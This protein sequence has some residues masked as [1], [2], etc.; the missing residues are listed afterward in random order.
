MYN[1]NQA[2]SMS[3]MIRIGCLIGGLLIFQQTTFAF[4]S[5][6]PYN[7]NRTDEIK[8][9]E[10]HLMALRLDDAN[11]ALFQYRQ[12]QP[13]NLLSVYLEHYSDF[14]Y[15]LIT[16]DQ[17]A[18]ERLKTS[19]A[20]RRE[21]ISKGPSTS[22]WRG[23]LMA[24]ISLHQ[25]GL[26]FYGSNFIRGFIGMRSAYREFEVN[27]QSHP[28]F[29]TNQKSMGLLQIMVTAIPSRYARSASFL[30]GI[31]ADAVG[32]RRMMRTAINHHRPLND[33]IYKESSILY[34]FLLL[35][36]DGKQEEAYQFAKAQNWDTRNALMP[37]FV[38]ANLAIYTGRND[39]AVKL[40]NARPTGSRYVSIPYIYYMHGETLLRAGDY[41]ASSVAF[42]KFVSNEKGEDYKKD[43]LQKAAWA[44]LL[45]NN[46]TEY[47]N[48][49]NRI[50]RTGTAE[51]NGDKA[52]EKEARQ[53]PVPH[54]ELLRAGL[55]YD[56][57]YYV[58]SLATLDGIPQS[59]LNQAAMKSEFHYRRAR[60]LDK[61]KRHEEAKVEFEL[62]IDT[63]KNL[64][65]HFACA[66]ALRFGQ[67]LESLGNIEKARNAF[68]TCLQLKPELYADGLHRQAK[69]ALNR[70][71]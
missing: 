29:I 42:L 1:I 61:L 33:F 26:Q 45:D 24:E 3:F 34:A 62:A 4:N 37:N 31:P 14:V 44:M 38:L 23:F 12:R 53:G 47:R 64:K 20:Q 15:A 13:D 40:L 65:E 18:I 49:M 6:N 63:G 19:S 35:H 43:A 46:Q 59:E 66:A 28:D 8:K 9:I 11:L 70:L 68:N 17:A 21:L 54:K 30:S 36:L 39:D 27:Q 2:L 25:A 57:G 5:P 60:T 55:E 56:G 10:E 41:K 71:K 16:S 58:R 51:S 48:L 67:M 52:A 32:G 69:A 7:Y 50:L 22:P